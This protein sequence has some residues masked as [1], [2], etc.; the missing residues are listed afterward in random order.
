MRTPIDHA[1]WPRF[2]DA[3]SQVLAGSEF[4][5]TD[6]GGQQGDG[7]LILNGLSYDI[8]DNVLWVHT[9]QV[10]HELEAP[11]EIWSHE[12]AEGHL[13]ALEV[14]T[15]DTRWMLRFRVPAATSLS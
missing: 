3:V 14:Q 2:I 10:E 6:S 5:L 7:W 11:R 9:D 8:A 12:D 1:D 13:Q 15:A 4:S